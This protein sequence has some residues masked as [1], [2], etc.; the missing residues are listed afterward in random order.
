MTFLKVLLLTALV[1]VAMACGSSTPTPTPVPTPT[2]I[3]RTVT[4]PAGDAWSLG[5]SGFDECR[6]NFSV[7]QTGTFGSVDIEFQ[8]ERYTEK[9]GIFYGETFTLS[10]GYSLTTAKVV[11]VRLRCEP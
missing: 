6:Y 9:D 4:I 5:V 11:D 8:G 10:N 2:V 3:H 1:L 7:R